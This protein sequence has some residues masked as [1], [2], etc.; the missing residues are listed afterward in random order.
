VITSW[1]SRPDGSD[2]RLG[3]DP[4]CR[5]AMNPTMMLVKYRSAKDSKAEER[6]GKDSKL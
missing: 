4:I 5:N 2:G 1:W 3:T 6:Q